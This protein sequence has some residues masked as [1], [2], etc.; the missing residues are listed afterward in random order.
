MKDDSFNP[1]FVLMA[2]LL[3]VGALGLG[4]FAHRSDQRAKEAKR[5]N[6]TERLWE[7]Q[8]AKVNHPDTEFDKIRKQREASTKALIEERYQHC[9]VVAKQ[10][11][12]TTAKP[13]GRVFIPNKEVAS[14]LKN[15][16]TSE[17]LQAEYACEPRECELIFGF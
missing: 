5:L 12:D 15:R 9:L 10:W 14:G 7:S 17:G 11:T 3:M 6:E 16:L 1:I 4:S 8:E 13:Q 2:L